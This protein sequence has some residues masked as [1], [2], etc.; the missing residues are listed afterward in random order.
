MQWVAAATVLL[1]IAGG[2]TRWFFYQPGAET[3]VVS[4]GVGEET[5]V[6][7]DKIMVEATHDEG[8]ALPDG[9][10]VYIRKESSLTYSKDFEHDRSLTLKGEAHFKVNKRQGA[11]PF[12]V[13]TDGMAIVATGTEFKVQSYNAER[14]TVVWLYE[15]GLNIRRGAKR[16]PL[17]A[18]GQLIYDKELDKINVKHTIIGMPRAIDDVY[19]F[20]EETLGDIFRWLEAHYG[21]PIDTDYI[22]ADIENTPVAL[23]NFERDVS[24]DTAL[25][26]LSIIT[27]NFGYELVKENGILRVKVFAVKTM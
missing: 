10:F 23:V 1:V 24:L 3:P 26:N 27:R 20:E 9:S 19:H 16:Y 8:M 2:V 17:A 11:S 18:G 5:I 14:Y 7:A 21:V 6:Y 22:T 4:A 15:G 25:Q 12:T 13:N